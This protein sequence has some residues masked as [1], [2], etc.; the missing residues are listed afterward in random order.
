VLNFPPLTVIDVGARGGLHRRWGSCVAPVLGIGF[1]AD[2]AECDRL[3]S[4]ATASIRYLPYALGSC[5]GE[6]ATL[7]VTRSLG[8]SSLLR[9]NYA[10]IRNFPY[11]A[12]MTVEETRPVSVTT[13]D[14]VC[15]DEGLRPDV[16]KIDVQGA[17]LSV[18]RGAQKTLTSV[19]CVELEVNFNP[20]YEGQPLFG[21]VDAFLRHRG[22]LLLG[23][24][25]NYWRRAVRAR[26][27]SPGGGTLVHGDALYLISVALEASEGSTLL[28]AL[29]VF[30][31]YKQMDLVHCLIDRVGDENVRDALRRRLDPPPPI[32]QRTAGAV[33]FRLDR[34]HR[35]WRQRLDRCRGPHASDWN[36]P[37]E[38]F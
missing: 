10:F 16:L 26:S 18:L 31:A 30:A 11:G 7:H 17:E 28:K 9:P 19:L 22:F 23:L 8:S 36:D 6:M 32:W 5:D 37:D 33:L 24:R 34:D 21:D 3:N 20:Q 13:L 1:E 38:F 27:H 35:R 4:V 29:A 2:A 25:R 15:A 12:G 14:R